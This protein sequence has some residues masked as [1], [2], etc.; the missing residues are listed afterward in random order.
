MARVKAAHLHAAATHNRAATLHQEAAA[1][2]DG[3]GLASLARHEGPRAR[4]D[5]EAAVAEREHARQRREWF[6]S[7]AG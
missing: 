1:L 5:R 6:E 7:H 3:M 4:L 2:Y